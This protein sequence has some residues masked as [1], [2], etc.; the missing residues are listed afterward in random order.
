MKYCRSKG[1]NYQRINDHTWL[2]RE[3]DNQA[4]DY[5]KHKYWK[6]YKVT[7]LITDD[8]IG[9]SYSNAMEN[10]TF[11]EGIEGEVKSSYDEVV[12]NSE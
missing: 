1:R 10:M 6:I 4:D 9:N 12:R 2:V 3:I 11:V 5:S 8:L 7:R